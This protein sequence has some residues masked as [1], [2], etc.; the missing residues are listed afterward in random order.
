MI[1]ITDKKN[2][3]GC[4]A[5][6]QVCPKH[7][8]SFQTDAEGFRYPQV[9]INKCINCSLCEQVCPELNVLTSRR[10]QKVYA[11]KHINAQIRGTSS[12]GGIFTLLAGYVL[13]EAGVVFGARYN[14]HW[15]VIHDYTET[16]DGLAAFRGSK[17]VQSRIGDTY[18]QAEVFLKQNRKVLFSGTPCQIAGLKLF[19]RKEYCNLI[20]VDFVCH[21]VPSPFVW[22]IYL[23]ELQKN[24]ASPISAITFRDKVTGWKQYSFSLYDSKGDVAYTNRF[25]H[26]PY[27][28]VFLAN[29][30]LRPSCYVCPAKAGRSMSDVT[31]GDF[32][33][34]QNYAPEIDDDKGV[35]LVMTYNPTYEHLLSGCT[36]QEMSY[37]QATEQNSCIEKSVPQPINRNFFWQ[38]LIH[39]G[40]ITKAAKSCGSNDFF[41]RLRRMVFRK[42]KI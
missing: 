15:E 31:I 39:F 22:T 42:F 41:S 35:S 4:E 38:H 5:C 12:S 25:Y 33:G 7:C 13:S 36:K 30:S 1:Q 40:S 2:C 18:R 32:W 19:L 21:G 26:D 16:Q 9:D 6:V 10:P 23:Q 20:T 28:Q 11:A 3:C 37:Q 8:I 29:L 34:I 17:Y 24:T 27:M 14:D